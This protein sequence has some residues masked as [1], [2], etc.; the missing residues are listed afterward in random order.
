MSEDKKY[1]RIDIIGQ[2]GN[3][4]LHYGES[5]PMEFSHT[6]TPTPPCIAH[7]QASD[8][9]DEMEFIKETLGYAEEEGLLTEVVYFALK[10]MKADPT[11][12]PSVALQF[13]YS[14][15]IK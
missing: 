4:G 12:S 11:I 9:L 6:P 15:W 1:S 14:E 7:S 13:G 2:N 5:G 3:E 10:E 8:E